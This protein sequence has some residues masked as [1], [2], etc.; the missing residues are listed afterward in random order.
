[1]SRGTVVAMLVVSSS[2][3]AEPADSG[4][5]LSEQQSAIVG[6]TTVQPGQWPDAVAVIAT[7]GYC[8]GTLIAPDVVLTAGHC[9][10][11]RPLE[12]IAD[13]IDFASADGVRATVASTQA[14]VNWQ[15]S[16]DVAVLVLAS[17]I[18]EVAPRKLGTT[19]TFDRF[20]RNTQ[21]RLVGFGATNASGSQTNSLLKQ[22]FTVVTDPECTGGNGCKQ[23]VSPGGEFVAGGTGQADSCF[24]D[25][26]GPVYLDTPGGAVVVGV[27]SRGLANATT[28]CGSGGIYVRTDKLVD[29]I[30]QTT[31]KQV[32]TDTCDGVPYNND[33]EEE[34]VIEGGGGGSID[35]AS[36]GGSG[37]GVLGIVIVVLRRK[38]RAL[39]SSA[40]EAVVSGRYRLPGGR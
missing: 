14:Y 4:L 25:S 17:P 30:A 36:G 18:G 39:A 8:T 15:T 24:G 29:W 31:G 5:P 10:K 1:M 37:F 26:G 13:T 22:A 2:A 38:R 23:A 11:L 35:C 6:G 34:D 27:V 28:P 16:Y 32:A 19:C 20:A 33:D 21:V 7:T 12:V 40:C 9:A 3:C